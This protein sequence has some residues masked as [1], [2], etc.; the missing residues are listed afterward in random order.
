M[1]NQ[2]GQN[3][4]QTGGNE[5]AIEH[6]VSKNSITTGGEYPVAQRKNYSVNRGPRV[7]EG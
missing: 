2:V 3:M 7:A 5:Q 4:V 1:L 6:P